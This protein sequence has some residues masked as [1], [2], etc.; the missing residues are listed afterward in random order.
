V[1]GSVSGVPVSGAAPG[2]RNRKK[3]LYPPEFRSSADDIELYLKQYEGMM[4]WNGWDADQSIQ[5]LKI[6]MP[7]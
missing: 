4:E 3:P 5:Y 1:G 7:A 6:H 2:T